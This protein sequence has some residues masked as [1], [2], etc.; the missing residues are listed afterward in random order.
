V[1]NIEFE[2]VK[3]DY[4]GTAENRPLMGFDGVGSVF[5]K[6]VTYKNVAGV[7]PLKYT[8]ATNVSLNG[9]KSF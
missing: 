3:L 6:N 1:K 9:F 8:D 4:A 7:E 2:D 5:L